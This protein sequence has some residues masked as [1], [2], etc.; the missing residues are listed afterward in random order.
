MLGPSSRWRR[1]R[2]RL[3]ILAAVG[4]RGVAALLHVED[5]D[6]VVP[7]DVAHRVG[8]VGVEVIGVVAIRVPAAAVEVVAQ[9]GLLEAAAV[10]RV[11]LVARDVKLPIGV[12]PQVVRGEPARSAVGDDVSAGRRGVDADGGRV[13]RAG[14]GVRGRDVDLVVIVDGDR[15]GLGVGL[16]GCREQCEEHGSREEKR[17][18]DAG[19]VVVVAVDVLHGDSSLRHL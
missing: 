11:D 1:A 15:D 10:P 16:G 13:G 9:V 2:L 12:S 4:V 7:L 8:D 5:G 6:S 19:V 17:G 14:G 3:E 18:G